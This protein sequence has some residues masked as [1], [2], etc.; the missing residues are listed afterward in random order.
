MNT[1]LTDFLKAALAMI[2]GWTAAGWFLV[3]LAGLLGLVA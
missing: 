1:A 2:I 3:A